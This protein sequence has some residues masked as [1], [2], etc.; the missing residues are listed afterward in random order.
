MEMGGHHLFTEHFIW[1][2]KCYL[3]HIYRYP[4][5]DGRGSH[6]AETIL[7]PGDRVISDGGTPEEVL[8]N[9]MTILPVAILSRSLL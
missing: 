4:W 8:Q 2:G 5:C 9:H 6:I 7:G 1:D 3:I